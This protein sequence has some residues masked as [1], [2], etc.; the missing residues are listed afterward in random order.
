[1]G[2]GLLELNLTLVSDYLGFLEKNKGYSQH[3]IQA[4]QTDLLEFLDS[5]PESLLSISEITPQQSR[6]VS[7]Y[8]FSSLKEKSHQVASIIRKT[9]A[10]KGWFKWL[11][12]YHQLQNNPFEWLE[13][14]KHKRRHPVLLTPQEIQCVLHSPEASATEKL[15]I[16]LL[17]ACGLRVSELTKLNIQDVALGGGYVKCTGKGNKQRIVPLPENT[18]EN[19]RNY[20]I[21]DRFDH[22]QSQQL[23]MNETG[24]PYT[25]FQIY[26]LVQQ[27][28]K[29]LGKAISPHTFRH[30]FATHLLENGAD[31]RVV[32]ELLGHEDIAT[33]QWYTQVSAS[34]LKKAYQ[35]AF[36]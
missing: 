33:T 23:L 17:Y 30:S 32:Q 2:Q 21:H 10:V 4:Y 18:L 7:L 14:P 26:R 1:M 3:T 9:S 36:S 28:G 13:L 5:Q 22:P 31:L 11:K 15:I 29:K 16:E 27:L 19:I 12:Q 25:R 34:H 24:E 20:L 6:Q 35:A 8:Y